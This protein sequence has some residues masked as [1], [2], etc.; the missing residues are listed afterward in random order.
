MVV[1]VN[2]LF[3]FA[4]C[5]TAMEA[6]LTKVREARSERGRYSANPLTRY[7]AQHLAFPTANM[8]LQQE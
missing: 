4:E 6:D 1:C 3:F 8:T 5:Q 7:I 2:R